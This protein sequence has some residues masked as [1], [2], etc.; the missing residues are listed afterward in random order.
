VV[1]GGGGPE[2]KRSLGNMGIDGR[3]ILK[4]IFREWNGGDMNCID[5]AQDRDR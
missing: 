3:I 5:L 4:R 1:G 2:R